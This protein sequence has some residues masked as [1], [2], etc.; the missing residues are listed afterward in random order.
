MTPVVS[1]SRRGSGGGANKLAARQSQGNRAPT[2]VM[3]P[4]PEYCA[5]IPLGSFQPPNPTPRDTL[6]QTII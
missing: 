2:G 3:G 5:G 6:K 1:V 4:G